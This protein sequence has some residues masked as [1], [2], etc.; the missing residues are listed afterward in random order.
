MSSARKIHCT[1]YYWTE[2][3]VARDKTKK[4]SDESP[5]DQEHRPGDQAHQAYRF[6]LTTRNI[7][8]GCLTFGGAHCLT[9]F[10]LLVVF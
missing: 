7:S 1:L 4:S 6:Q 8:F 10:G 2:Q 3:S 5:T 9:L